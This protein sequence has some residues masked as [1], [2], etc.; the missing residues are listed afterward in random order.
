MNKRVYMHVLTCSLASEIIEQ[1]ETLKASFPDL[2]CLVTTPTAHILLF[3]AGDLLAW[4]GSITSRSCETFEAK[5]GE[6]RE[7]TLFV[8]RSQLENDES[9]LA[10]EALF[11]N[12]A[13][14]TV[15]SWL[16][17]SPLVC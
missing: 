2:C 7:D 1:T 16:L 14:A 8:N 3:H 12:I 10:K 11:R 9:I 13:R 5:Q 15:I 17:G 6:V 4:F